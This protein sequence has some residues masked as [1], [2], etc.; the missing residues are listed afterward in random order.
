MSSRSISSSSGGSS[1][2]PLRSSNKSLTSQGSSSGGFSLSDWTPPD[3]HSKQHAISGS[4]QDESDVVISSN[5]SSVTIPERKTF[6]QEARTEQNVMA[7]PTAGLNQSESSLSYTIVPRSSALRVS[8]SSHQITASPSSRK[9]LPKIQLDEEDGFHGMTINKLQFD[10]HLYGRETHIQQLQHLFEVSKT[11]RQL[12]LIHGPAGSG[13]SMLVKEALGAKVRRNKGFLLTGKFNQRQQKGSTAEFQPYQAMTTACQ[14]LV[15][16]L[17]LHSKLPHAASGF[18]FS[19]FKFVESFQEQFND[20]DKELLNLIMP[21]LDRL[22]SC[23]KDEEKKS[24]FDENLQSD[25]EEEKVEVRRQEDDR[26]VPRK[27]HGGEDVSSP[28]SATKHA[29]LLTADDAGYAETKQVFHNV[30]RRFFQ[31]LVSF[32]PVALVL[33]DVQWADLASLE[34]M[35]SLVTDLDNTK[36]ILVLALY[37]DEDE[38][39]KA[40]KKW[41]FVKFLDHLQDTEDSTTCVRVTDLSVPHLSKDH[42]AEML[43][44]LLLCTPED[45]AIAGLAA[46]VHTKT[47]GNAFFVKQFLL[48]LQDT[49]LLQFNFGRLSWSF[50][51]SQIQELAS[52]T[53]N[54]VDLLKAKMKRLPALLQAILPRVACLGSR[55]LVS[56][57]EVVAECERQKM[58]QD[59]KIPQ[60]S[61]FTPMPEIEETEGEENHH[62]S[63]RKLLQPRGEHLVEG[64]NV[65]EEPQNMNG[66]QLEDSSGV[67]NMDEIGNETPKTAAELELRDPLFLSCLEGGFIVECGH[68]W[69][70]WE[71]DKIQEA[72]LRSVEVSELEAIQ[73][74]VGRLLLYQLSDTD[75]DRALFVVTNLLNCGVVVDETP[76]RN[77]RRHLMQEDDPL[78]LVVAKLNLRAGKAA[79][80][81][82]AFSN[83]AS[84][85]RIGIAL[86]PN[87]H[88]RWNEAHFKFSLDFYST[89]AETQFCVGNFKAANMYCD[90]ILELPESICPLLDKR[91]AYY[92]VLLCLHAQ[93]RPKDGKD[94]CLEVLSKLGC[95][96]P[97][98]AKGMFAM[99]GAL[100]AVMELKK[101]TQ[102]LGELKPVQDESKEWALEL[103]ERLIQL[104]YQCD[105]NILYLAILKAH[106]WTIQYGT[107]KSTAQILT[108]IAIMLVKYGDFEAARAYC[109]YSYQVMTPSVEANV[110]F[111]SNYFAV[112]WLT[113]FETIK[114]SLLRGY[115]IGLRSGDLESAFWCVYCYTEIVFYLGGSLQ[116][117][118]K[119]C[120]TYSQQMQ[121]FNQGLFVD[122]TRIKLQFY[123]NLTN[124]DSNQHV[125]TGEIM[126]ED[127]YERRSDY[128]LRMIFKRFQVFAAFWF[129][130]HER[131]VELVESLGIHQFIYEKASPGAAGTPPFYCYCALSCFIVAGKTRNKKYK[132]FGEILRK[133]IKAWGAKGNPNTHHLECLLDAE[134]NALSGSRVV[135]IKN[136]G[137]AVLLAGR[138]GI[139]SD[140]ALIHERYAEA[141][142]ASGADD[143]DISFHFSKARSLYREWGAFAKVA[144]MP[145]YDTT[146][147]ELSNPSMDFAEQEQRESFSMARDEVSDLSLRS[148]AEEE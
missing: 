34:L 144:K 65:V 126:K 25:E 2:R 48:T 104:A 83:A 121:Q 46:V 17:C 140:Q 99:G 51:L 55:F 82:S 12:A 19:T 136:F 61:Q 109:D 9:K 62:N 64:E 102:K 119:D 13:K 139:T 143:S 142:K 133:R 91:R 79:F 95:K 138:R 63:D 3:N 20:K 14:E 54:V 148:E 113:P 7:S 115:D 76:G 94:V 77:S 100:R 116:S 125:L 60:E 28:A 86:L 27:K 23:A 147:D 49:Q 53:D 68:G 128:Q 130:N 57:F 75:L 56:M 129:G 98:V 110:L 71:H 127:D 101:T 1:H 124:A 26:A 10:S 32:G 59:S 85:L 114:K 15:E 103:L 122:L 78:R 38:S 43:G 107:C 21:N 45:D 37:R 97:K 18:G 88:M 72:A 135:D 47:A 90:Q 134:V 146:S 35:E 42:V 52:S 70:K 31:F 111:V 123:L 108:K 112:H 84:Y 118:I 29:P 96:F 145:V 69:C 137:S 11:S 22:M 5:H 105:P 6:A 67:G 4:D 58:P 74:D 80:A 44:D 73:F 8:K 87:Q 106:R 16:E 50:D 89:A 30:C 131:V 132:R 117:L 92:V 66:Y 81:S 24:D 39:M 33:D 141:L 120:E 41:I 93:G 40:N 36:G